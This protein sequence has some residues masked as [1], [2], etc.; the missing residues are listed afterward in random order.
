MLS[1]AI[2]QALSHNDTAW[3]TLIR[4]LVAPAALVL[5]SPSPAPSAMVLPACP[6]PGQDQHLCCVGGCVSA[7]EDADSML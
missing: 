6:A 7:D 5:A 1:L 2:D 3:A 4:S